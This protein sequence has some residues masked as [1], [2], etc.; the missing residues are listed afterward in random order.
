[1]HG[2]RSAGHAGQGADLGALTSGLTPQGKTPLSDAVR[3]A[4]ETL[5]YIEEAATV[6]LISDGVETC[7]AD[8][9]ALA[10]E[11]ERLGIDFTAHVV[12]FDIAAADRAQLQCIADGTGGLYFDASN[13]SGLVTAFD[14]VAER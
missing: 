8:P 4:A 14:A 13:A 11:L 5:R 12:G 7:E 6:V 1:M 9:C 10:A 3:R 2:H